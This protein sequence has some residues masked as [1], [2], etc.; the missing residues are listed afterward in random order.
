M[1][2]TSAANSAPDYGN[3]EPLDAAPSLPI[4]IVPRVAEYRPRREGCAVGGRGLRAG[5]A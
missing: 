5:E 4:T 1:L 2:H 3:T